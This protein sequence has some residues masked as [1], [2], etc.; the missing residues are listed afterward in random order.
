[1]RTKII[2]SFCVMVVSAISFTVL[3]D[4]PNMPSNPDTP[5]VKICQWEKDSCGLFKGD[6]EIC[7]M[8]GDGFE[9]GCGSVTRKC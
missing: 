2:A 3:A 6:R 8:T 4:S 1:M 7:V 5:E 9:C